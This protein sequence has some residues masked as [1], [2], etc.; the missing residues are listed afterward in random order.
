MKV[1]INKI[2]DYDI[3]P[4]D[5]VTLITYNKWLKEIL[6]VMN[7]NTEGRIKLLPG[8]K[9]K[10]IAT[11][12][13]KQCKKRIENRSQGLGSL[14]KTFKKIR[15]TINTNCDDVSK[16]MMVTLTYS[17][18]MT[19]TKKFDSD[20]NKFVKKFKYRYGKS[21]NIKVCEAQSTG[22]LHAH[23]I[24]IW[25][26][27][28]PYLN[29]EEVVKLWNKGYVKVSPLYGNVE[30][31]GAYFTARLSDLP[32]DEF[33]G[34]VNDIEENHLFVKEIYYDI[35]TGEELEIPKFFV[36]GARLKY[37]PPNFRIFRA[38]RG[39]KKPTRE[40]MEYRKALKKV[41]SDE[42]TYESAI[43]IVDSNGI[44]LNIVVRKYYNSRRFP[45]ECDTEPELAFDIFDDVSSSY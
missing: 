42:P 21:E 30:N 7:K 18:V 28:A 43:Q 10:N 23:I 27:I 14:R 35:E 24:F 31:L 34:I 12:E 19:D 39:L 1:N 29:S 22:S 37:Y 38:S 15:D 4:R 9:Y 5:E 32:I 13:I 16:C 2:S 26:D 25:E 8:G 11:G 20:I 36:K 45:L 41:D 17:E 6:Y 44:E 3:D 40:K 33:G